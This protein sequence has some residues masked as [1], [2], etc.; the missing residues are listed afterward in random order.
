MKNLITLI[1]IAVVF[2]LNIFSQQNTGVFRVSAKSE[3]DLSKVV[4]GITQ[5]TDQTSNKISPLLN[6]F[7]NKINIE[8]GIKV[9]LPESI[10]TFKKVIYFYNDELDDLM[11][12]IFI[13][14]NSVYDAVNNIKMYK[15]IISTIA[16][17]II[18]A[19][20]P[21]TSVKEIALSSEILYVDAST[22]SELKIDVSRL[23]SKVNQ[24]HD[25]TGIYRQ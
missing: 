16:G 18:T 2:S 4:Q 21:V 22:I 19:E 24:L 8:K 9:R 12:P 6:I 25:V 13:K 3:Q 7:L 20:V 10:D 23:E 5:Y 17:D 11:I 14:T 15:G 1:I